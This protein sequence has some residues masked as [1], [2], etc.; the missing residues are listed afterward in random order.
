MQLTF[1]YKSEF[2]QKRYYPD[3]KN[4]KIIAKLGGFKSFT[5]DQINMMKV[6]GWEL[7]FKADT[8]E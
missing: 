3:C 5:Q 1:V 8:P 2:G 4:S 7:E 6:E